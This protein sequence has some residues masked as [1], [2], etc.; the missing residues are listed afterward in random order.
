M[1]LTQGERK[2]NAMSATH[3]N[4]ALTGPRAIDNLGRDS[5]PSEDVWSVRQ[6][7]TALWSR[8]GYWSGSTGIAPFLCVKLTPY[9]SLPP[10]PNAPNAP[11][12]PCAPIFE[13]HHP[14][15]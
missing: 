8:A 13:H 4:H 9:I 2:L 11:P 7:R 10:T 6:E 14:A 5:G 12:E 3:D 15:S 1:S